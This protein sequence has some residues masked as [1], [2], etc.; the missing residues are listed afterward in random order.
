MESLQL[1]R[2]LISPIAD[3]N[4]F[5]EVDN[6]STYEDREI[7]EIIKGANYQK[8]QQK[9]DEFTARCQETL[10]GLQQRVTEA[11]DEHKS[12]VRIADS[13]KPGMAPTGI[14]VDRS[15]SNSVARHNS[16]VEQYN[17]QIDLHRRL[18]DK[19]SRAKERYEDA[20]ERYKDKKSDLDERIREKK[21][22]LKPALDQDIVAFFGK[23]Q[24]LVYDCI[25][26]KEYVFEPFVLIY[27]AK[28]AYLFLYDRIENP[29]NQKTSSD[30]FKQLNDELDAIVESHTPGIQQGLA[31]IFAYIYNSYKENEAVFEQIQEDMARL[32]YAECE[33]NITQI[34][35]LIAL[36]IKTEFSYENIIDP[37]ELYRIEQNVQER[38]ASFESGTRSIDSFVEIVSPH[39]DLIAEVKEA[40]N[41]K[42]AQMVH[43]K[44]E[45]L[46]EAFA[47]SLFVLSVFNESEQDEYLKKQKPLLEEIQVDIEQD[48]GVELT[49]LVKT[50][51]TTELLTRSTADLLD[52]DPGLAF[53]AHKSQLEQKKKQLASAISTLDGTL[54]GINRLPEQKAAEFAD[55]LKQFL[56][57]SVLP[58]GNLGVLMPMQSLLKTF[59]PALSSDNST[60]ASLR[61]STSS[62]LQSFL[63]VHI[64][65]VVVSGLLSLPVSKDQKGW[66]YGLA[67]TYA[68]SALVL[69]LKKGE[70][71]KL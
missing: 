29:I 69:Q 62:Q 63:Y 56:G 35:E 50:I 67:S 4:F 21:E 32:P 38:K 9:V 33:R 36:P 14:F 49:K 46:G 11:R 64:A 28:K 37:S 1:I 57:L 22:D 25:H 65:L 31:E 3:V 58:L 30:T 55:K 39:F 20:Q 45:N 40:C 41:S 27:M 23:L 70:L 59:M 2:S 43:N 66:L 15:D 18:V 6:D 16:K 10:S 54:Q 12:A 24:Q 19:A 51:T 17:N 42:L 47:D 8:T 7:G 5:I 52:A 48:L 13:E 61:Q 68:A 71:Q 60:Y 34:R 26:N 44:Q 53:L